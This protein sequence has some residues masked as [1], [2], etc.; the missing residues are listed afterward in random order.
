[1]LP[2]LTALVAMLLL[3]GQ[4]NIVGPPAPDFQR[5]AEVARH[6]RRQKYESWAAMVKMMRPDITV[7]LKDMAAELYLADF[8]KKTKGD[9]IW[10]NRSQTQ[11]TQKSS[12]KQPH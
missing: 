12:K 2:N 1:M 5:Q 4:G 9:A 7:P 8:K 6:K 11:N 3:S 10:Q